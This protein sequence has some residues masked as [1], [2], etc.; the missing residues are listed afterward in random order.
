VGPKK[1]PE[2]L[3]N[4]LTVST[5]SSLGDGQLPPPLDR[6]PETEAELRMLIN[7]LGDPAAFS[8]WFERLMEQTDPAERCEDQ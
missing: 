4:Y 5:V 6:P 7:H 1:S 8:L 3:E 2:P